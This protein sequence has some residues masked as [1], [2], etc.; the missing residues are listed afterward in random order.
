MSGAIQTDIPARLDRL[1]WSRFHLLVV[2][3]LGVTWILDGL[4]V[5]IVGSLG[6]VLQDKRTLGLTPQDIGSVASI[7]V[8]GAV[9]GALFFGWLTDRLGRKVIFNVTLGIYVLGVL[10]SAFAWDFWSFAAFRFITGLGIGG[11]YAAINSAI[12]ELMPARLRGRIDLMV[13]GSY[14][15]GAAAGAAAS[16]PLLSG[17]FVPLDWGWRL[18]FGIGGVLGIS[19]LFLRHWVPESPR[20]LVTHGKEAEGK[21]T[22]DEIEQRVSHSG[23]GAL[24]K[25]EGVLTVHPR[26][27]F[28][29]VPVFSAMLGKHRG[30]SCLA[31]V[32]MVAQA[33]L[34]NAVFFTYGLVLQHYEGVPDAHIGLYILPLCLGNLVGPFALGHLFDTVGRKKMIAGTYAISG[35]LLMV[36]AVLFGMGLLTATTQTLCWVGVFF[37]ASAAASSAYLTASEIFPLE[38]RALAIAVFYALGTLIGGA[39]APWLFG[40]LIAAGS[41]WALSAGYC[42]AGLLMLAG[43]GMELWLG[44]DAE[45]KSLEDIAEPLSA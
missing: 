41:A 31:L 11:E 45:G 38:T 36:V 30:R 37:F 7:Y 16:I 44:I 42:V 1:P 26:K 12:D 17:Q 40:K 13:N 29:F 2:I 25:A 32:L 39:A 21:R 19:I 10:L 34:F 3:G 28:G 9:V 20:W 15:A 22:I 33:F 14:W 6:P 43:A 18:G 4:E 5:T 35:V 8:M 27:V 24:P 23:G